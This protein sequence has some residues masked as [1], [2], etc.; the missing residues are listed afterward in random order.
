MNLKIFCWNVQGLNALDKRMA[1]KSFIKGV[2][3]DIICLQENKVEVS[4]RGFVRDILG[5]G[6]LCGLG[7]FICSLDGRRYSCMLEQ[8]NSDTGGFGGWEFLGFMFV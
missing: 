2:L 7:V 4:D 3:A 1:V 6:A 5:G 8:S